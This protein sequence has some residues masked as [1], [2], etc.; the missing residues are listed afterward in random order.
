MTGIRFAGESDER[1]IRIYMYGK[2]N[3]HGYPVDIW[4]YL[5]I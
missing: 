1:R 4:Q 2:G 3:I 5:K